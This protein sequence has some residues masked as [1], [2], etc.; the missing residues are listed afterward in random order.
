MSAS[1][2]ELLGADGP[3]AGALPGFAPRETQQAMAQAVED[4]VAER[5]TL[6][7]EAG[8]GTGKTFAYLLPA[9]QSGR[10][11]LIATGTRALQDQL[12]HRDLPTLQR[13]L[14]LSVD[15]A[16]LKGRANYLC[17]H[18]LERAAAGDFG[19]DLA[20]HPALAA[21]SSFASRSPDGDLDALEELSPQSS[22]RPFVTSNADNCL[23][24]ECPN[25]GDCFL[26][27]ARR[28]AQQADVVVV[29]HHLFFA[30]LALKESGFG[31][32]L[33]DAD[34]FIFDEAHLL[35]DV[36]TMFFGTSLGSFQLTDLAR[37]LAA[38]AAQLGDLPDLPP[39]AQALSQAAAGLHTALG[40][41][42]RR[43]PW[44]QQSVP[45]FTAALEG[46]QL[47]LA[48]LTPP[49]EAFAGRSSG[50]DNCQERVAL[51]RE[52]LQPFLDEAEVDR[53]RWIDVRQRSC[54]LHASP[55]DIAPLFNERF[56]RHARA[57]VFTSGTL[58]VAGEFG[59]FVQRLGLG[60]ARTLA[61]PGGFDYQT[62][63]MLYLPTGLPE[64]SDPGYTDALV[65]AALPVLRASRGRAFMLF[66]SHN[67]LRRA[68]TRLRGYDEFTLLV[69]GERPNSELLTQFR[70]AQAPV[71]LG[72]GSFWQGVDVRGE[73]LSCVIVDK[74]PFAS[75][76]EP[77]VAGRIAYLRRQGADPF[78][79]YQLPHAVITL[80]QGLGRLIRDA[81]DRGVLMV[82]DKRLRARGYGR[83]FL[84]SLPAMPISSELADVQRFFEE[85]AFEESAP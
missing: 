47:A 63:A 54:T 79:D 42:A 64:P 21:V 53:V 10:K 66:T 8:T 69:Q 7:V 65:A 35:P 28:A 70:R 18:R 13:A 67:A 57:C 16:L 1:I 34:V 24:Q 50:L 78:N 31:E 48:D 85:P 60:D 17:H 77:I 81:G 80:K 12:F 44:P 38:E 15:T 49:L 76:G 73:A 29:N 68:A 23:G 14:G 59:H 43:E 71:L 25:I 19:G 62:R 6:L 52:H 3:L 2:T 32:V 55:V 51:L 20:L 39:L 84:R 75:P 9:L 4:A 83:V 74:L 5:G 56:P 37:D 46:V 40:D 72:T 30:D 36:A 26:L 82:G 45:K 58:A 33:P 61:L 41:P 27:K 11:V 22:L